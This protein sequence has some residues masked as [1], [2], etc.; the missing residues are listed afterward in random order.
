MSIVHS[1]SNALPMARWSSR[2]VIFAG[3]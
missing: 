3:L 1:H 2:H